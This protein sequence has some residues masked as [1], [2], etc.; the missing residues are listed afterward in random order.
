MVLKTQEMHKLHGIKSKVNNLQQ[1]VRKRM[2]QQW[3]NPMRHTRPAFLVGC[4]RSGT[5]MLV[6]HLGKS[7]RVDLYNE[8]NPAA[9]Q[10][11]R[12]RDLSVIEDLVQRSF[13]RVA[14][15]KPILNTTETLA[16]LDR[17]P[18]ARVIFTFRHY[19]DVINSSIKK[20]G[21]MNRIGHVKAWIEEDFGEFTAYPPPEETKIYI[22]SNWTAGM[23]PESGAALYWLFY[24]RLY[25]DQQLD[26]NERVLLVG[27]E[28]LVSKPEREFRRICQ[29]L[30]IEFDPR[31]IEGV[32]ASSVKHAMPANIAPVIQ[33]ECD[34]LWIR[35]C[36]EIGASPQL[37]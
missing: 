28:S 10:N 22:R 18:D 15:F 9:F 27:Y 16:L 17:F 26:Q 8:N 20:F 4:G 23:S 33:K 24:N 36:K 19:S 35:L 37:S 29:F 31:F 11:F 12:L 21:V 7:W 13:A 34:E 3:E 32:F 6:Y 5:S 2:W 1:E 25:F 14:L 30:D